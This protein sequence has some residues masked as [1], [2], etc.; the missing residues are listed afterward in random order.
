MLSRMAEVWWFLN[1]P[2]KEALEWVG[3]S[4]NTVMEAL[5]EGRS[6]YVSPI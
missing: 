6:A 4:W 5:V 3:S 2:E 1:K